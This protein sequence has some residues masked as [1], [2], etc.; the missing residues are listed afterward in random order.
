MT[1]LLL[2]DPNNESYLK[3]KADLTDAM[4]LTQDLLDT[5]DKTGGAAQGGTAAAPLVTR[6]LALDAAADKNLL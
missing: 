5:K 4:K 2:L 3:L 6:W 1:E